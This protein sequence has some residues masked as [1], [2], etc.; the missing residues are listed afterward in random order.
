MRSRCRTGRWRRVVVATLAAGVLGGTAVPGRDAT[1]ADATSEVV[2]AGFVFVPAELTVRVGTT[3]RWVN[4]EARTSHSIL[5][6]DGAESDRFFPGEQV[7]RRFDR[8]GRYAYRC[9]PH[10]EMQGAV[11]VTD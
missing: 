2:V 5:W 3:V 6:P 4:R 1:A 7:E 8:A 10:P 9:G 11:I